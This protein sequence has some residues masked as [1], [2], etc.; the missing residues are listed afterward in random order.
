MQ[1]EV[2]D[3]VYFFPNFFP[4]EKIKN[5]LEIINN[6]NI[7]IVT[8]KNEESPFFNAF[9]WVIPTAFGVYILKPYFEGF[10]G[11][12]AQIDHPFSDE[13]DHLFRSK[14]TTYFRSKLTT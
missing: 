11:K 13:I 2:P 1:K 10:F 14:L 12:T 6:S 5:E 3:L 7:K 8:H 9:E 4:E